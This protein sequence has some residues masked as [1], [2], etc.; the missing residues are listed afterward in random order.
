MCSIVSLAVGWEFYSFFKSYLFFVNFTL[1]TSVLLILFHISPLPL[2]HP[3]IREQ[4][5]QQQQISLWKLCCVTMCPPVHHFVLTAWLANV[6]AMSHHSGSRPLAFATLSMLDAY[7]DSFWVSC[8]W[9]VS[10][11]SCSFS[12]AGL[13]P[14]H[15]PAVYKC[16]RCWGGPT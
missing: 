13:A 16:G 12:S 1:Y 15:A 5:Q 10:W 8:C 2:H 4:Q 3:P 9:P 14:W 11:W 7:W 6:D